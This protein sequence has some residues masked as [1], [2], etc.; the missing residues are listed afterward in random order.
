MQRRA[1]EVERR[2]RRFINNGIVFAYHLQKLLISHF[3]CITLVKYLATF[4][5]TMFFGRVFCILSIEPVER[6][7]KENTC[8][9]VCPAEEFIANISS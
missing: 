9:F 3:N 5:R 4:F 7:R 8:S 2:K 1:L 6:A